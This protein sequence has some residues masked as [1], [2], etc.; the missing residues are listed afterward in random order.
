MRGILFGIL[1]F[2]SGA[3]KADPPSISK[4]RALYAQSEKKEEACKELMN[5]LAPYDEN[6]NP[7]FMGYKASA[8]MMMARF[9][10]NPFSK[11][12]YFN[13]GKKMLEK[14]VKAAPNNIEIR[15]LRF[16]VQSNVPSFLGYTADIENDKAFIISNAYLVKDEELKKN[17]IYFMTKWGKLTAAQTKILNHQ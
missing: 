4:V 15:S 10:S 7:V 2:I 12:S 1:I 13:K 6:N 17:I 3:V 16:L 11:L 14:A 5:I 8:T 9:A